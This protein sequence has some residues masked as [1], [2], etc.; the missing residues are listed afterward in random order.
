MATASAS[1]RAASSRALEAHRSASPD[2]SAEPSSSSSC[3]MSRAA[4][5]KP[6]VCE[7]GGEEDLLDLD[8][9]WVAAAEAEALMALE[10]IYGDDLAVHG[11]KRGLRYFRIYIRYD[12]PDGVGV[13]AKFSSDNAHCKDEGC[14]D[15]SG[16]ELPGQEV[17]YQW[18]EWLRCSSRSHLWFDGKMTLGPDIATH[19]SDNRAIL[20]TKFFGLYNP[21]DADI[22]MHVKEGTVFQLV[23]PDAKC[24][25][26]IPP[27]LL[28]RLLSKEEFERWDRLVLKKAL[29]SMSD[30][31]YCPREAVSSSRRKDPAP[32]GIRQDV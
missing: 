20:K 11:N 9:P 17:V 15:G 27:Y 24:N 28:K 23:C 8:S 18:V 14:S 6:V 29:D 1:P 22:Q 31:V 2:F 10:A 16:H 21:Y 19:N 3:T 4:E 32:A 5:L 7:G 30:L 12:V 25:A 26:S 13:C